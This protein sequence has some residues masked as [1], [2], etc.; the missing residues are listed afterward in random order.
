MNIKAAGSL[1]RYAMNNPM[2]LSKSVGKKGAG[3]ILTNTLI[4]ATYEHSPN[5]LWYAWKNQRDLLKTA[6]KEDVPAWALGRPGSKTAEQAEDYL[7]YFT[8][9]VNKGRPK[10]K[11]FSTDDVRGI[12]KNRDVPWRL[13]FGMKSRGFGEK[14]YDIDTWNKTRTLAFNKNTR[15]GRD[16]IR[17]AMRTRGQHSVMGYFTK[18]PYGYKDVWD[19][20]KNTPGLTMAQTKYLMKN[21]VNPTDIDQLM[22]Q[23]GQ[24]RLMGDKVAARTLISLQQGMKKGY[25]TNKALVNSIGKRHLRTALDT[26]TNPVKIEGTFL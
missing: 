16:L 19:F 22:L 1:L 6:I 3:R 17:E 2:G 21:L 24:R 25:G 20:A 23:L 9:L 26:V 13:N 5:A 4:P 11:Q 12:L 18:T 8:S 7:A 10:S 15:Q 14:A